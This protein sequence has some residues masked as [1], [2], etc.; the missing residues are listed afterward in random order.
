MT[1]G[2]FLL[3]KA[4]VDGDSFVIELADSNGVVRYRPKRFVSFSRHSELYSKA[5]RLEG[6]FVTTE[7]SNPEK[8]SPEQWWIDINAYPSEGQQLDSGPRS[9]IGVKTYG[10]AGALHRK[11]Q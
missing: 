7:T 8:N 6:S 9:G 2:P 1:F 3:K 4:Y 5:K 10:R 11:L